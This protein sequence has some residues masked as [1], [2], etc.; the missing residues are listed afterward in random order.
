M[1]RFIHVSILCTHAYVSVY[2]CVSLLISVYLCL[3]MCISVH[4]CVLD[5]FKPLLSYTETETERE[6]QT[7]IKTERYKRRNG[8]SSAVVFDR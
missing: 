8:S 6:R 7:D 4:L 1:Y 5:F 3:S 2:L